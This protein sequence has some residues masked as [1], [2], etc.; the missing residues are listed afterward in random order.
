VKNLLT[1]LAVGAVATT[2][3]HAQGQVLVG[4]GSQAFVLA[5]SQ[6][7]TADNIYNL[8]GQVYVGAGTTLTIEPGTVIASD[9]GGSLAVAR[10][11]QIFAEGNQGAP[12]IFTSVADRATWIGGDPLT[13]A[14]RESANEWGNITIMGSGYIAEDATPGNTPVPAA[15]NFADMEGL[16]PPAGSTLGQY[17]GDNDDDDSGVLSYVS[18]RYGGRVVALQN[19]LNGLSLGGIGRGTDID[20]IEIMNN[21]DD[22]IEIWGGTV[23]LKYFSIWNIG[24]DSLDVDQG[25]RGKAQF[26]LIAQGWSLDASQGSGVGDNCVEMDGA[27]DSD[28]QPVT[29]ASIYNMT[30]IGNPISGDGLTAWRDNARV[31]FRNSLFMFCGE[32]VVRFDNDDGDGAS[33][34]GHNGTLSWEDTWTTSYTQTSPVNAPANPGDF[35]QAQ[36]SGNLIEI[37]DSVFYGNSNGAAYTE[38]NARGVFAPANDNTIV[39]GSNPANAP[40]NAIAF[41]TPVSRGGLTVTRV[42]GLDPRPTG[43]AA[44]SVGVAP[45]DGFFSP[46][47]YR[48]AFDPASNGTWLNGWSASEA[49]GFVNAG[50]DTIGVNYCEA[51]PSTIGVP[52]SIRAYGSSAVAFNDVTLEATDLPAQTF[53]IFLVSQDEGFVPNLAGQDGNLCLDPATLARYQGPGQ[54]LQ[55]SASGTIALPIDLNAIPQGTVPVA[56]MSGDSWSFQAWFRDGQSSNLTNGVTVE[57]N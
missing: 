2:A 40:V 31:Q 53:G 26:G 23:N 15:S 36:T 1:T 6:T 37:T 18:L 48:G 41:A 16:T 9:P 30:I 51:N 49:Y 28:W 52:A 34:Y 29:T 12:I 25:W 43:A 42:V 8:Q 38:A 21:V 3:A 24:D 33:G 50:L 47:P 13:G 20:H 57:F 55:A 4:D 10:G 27:E 22:G 32:R 14:W 5:T 44:T 46:A 54:I 19:E 56:V 7:W 11:G 17:G 39:A 35:Y 45:N